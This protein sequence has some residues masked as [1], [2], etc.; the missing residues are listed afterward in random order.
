MLFIV[1]YLYLL[2]HLYPL[3]FHVIPS[4]PYFLGSLFPP[5]ALGGPL[6]PFR[7][8]APGSR[9]RSRI[10]P[11]IPATEFLIR[12]FRIFPTLDILVLYSY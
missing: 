8:E 2:D 12:Q 10:I 4:R 11:S 9:D 3:Y 7:L 5:G 6:D 1:N